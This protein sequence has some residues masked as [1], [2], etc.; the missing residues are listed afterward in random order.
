MWQPF[1]R[2]MKWSILHT[3]E[4]LFQ[5]V[6]CGKSFVWTTNLQRYKMI[7]KKEKL[8]QCVI[9]GKSFV[10]TTNLKRHEMIRY[11]RETVPVYNVW[12][13]FCMDNQFKETWNHPY[14]RETVPVQNMWQEF[15]MDNQE[16]WSDPFRPGGPS[17]QHRGLHASRKYP[18]G[19]NISP[20]RG[21]WLWRDPFL[22]FG[23]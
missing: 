2:D 11:W 12:Q 17:G 6:V 3:G 9:C 18:P 13:E 16:T 8:F 5:C 20:L 15:S 21:S 10:W 1:W 14:R 22:R 7:L 23:H 4:K 19:P